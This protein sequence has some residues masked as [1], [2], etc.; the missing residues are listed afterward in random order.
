M[1]V[2]GYKG[3]EGWLLFP[4]GLIQFSL[5]MREGRR[6]GRKDRR[7]R[8]KAE[9]GG[10]RQIMDGVASLAWRGVECLKE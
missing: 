1:C 6:E 3:R 5:W 10:G 7:E 2:R 8:R 4:Q 9:K